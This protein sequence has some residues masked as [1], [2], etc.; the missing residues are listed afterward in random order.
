MHNILFIITK[1]E[2]GGAQ[3]FVKEQVDITSSI[4]NVYLCTNKEGW[5]TNV[6]SRKV[7]SFLLNKGIEKMSSIRFLFSLYQFIKKNEINLVITNSANGGFYGRLAAFFANVPSCYFSHGWSS[8]YNGGRLIWVLNFIE[9]ILSKISQKVICVSDNDY[10]IAINKI[11]ISPVKLCVIKNAIFPILDNVNTMQVSSK[12]SFAIIAL[13][14]FAKPKRIDLMIKAF[15]QLPDIDLYIAG[16][17][18]D[19]KY[20]KDFLNKDK[21]IKNVTLLGEVPS[22][23]SFQIYSAFL[24]VSDSEGLP[25]SAMEAMSAGLPLILS[26]VGGCSELIRNNG[27]LVD[28]KVNDIVQK[29]L[30]I[31][32]NQHKFSENSK[33]FFN[34]HFNLN[35]T[36]SKYTDCYLNLIT[37]Y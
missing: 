3:K 2:V 29:V 36:S 4:F 15:K 28:N 16:S 20:W 12:N 34:Q 32:K 35:H 23:N 6:T 14:R 8:V 30:L 13:A 26:N 25:I 7:K 5:L 18:P 24:L 19:F 17:G 37:V 33:V 11:G 10:K 21:G 1:S 27:F 31:K 9:K 22:F